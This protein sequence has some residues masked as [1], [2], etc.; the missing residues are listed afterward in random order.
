MRWRLPNASGASLQVIGAWAGIGAVGFLAGCLFPWVGQWF[1]AASALLLIPFVLG[2][3]RRSLA[4]GIVFLFYLGFGVDVPMALSAAGGNA[5]LTSFF[6]LMACAV[7]A[8][9]PV[10]LLR[11]RYPFLRGCVAALMYLLP[12]MGVLVPGNPFLAIGVILPATGAVGVLLFVAVAGTLASLSQR[13]WRTREYRPQQK[14][15]IIALAV[16]PV[17]SNAIYLVRGPVQAPANWFAVSMASGNMQSSRLSMYREGPAAVERTWREKPSVGVDS[18][19]VLFFPEGVITGVEDGYKPAWL[20]AVAGR[21]LGVVVGWYR[22]L[23]SS[24][25]YESRIQV[26]GDAQSAYIGELS[27]MSQRASVAMPITMWNPLSATWHFPMQTLTPVSFINGIATRL[28]WCYEST[29]I[30]PHLL[31][32]VQG[33]QVMVSMENH[34]SY[35]GTSLE[36]AQDVT[37]TLVARWLGVHAL[38][39]INR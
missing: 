2:A 36:R 24:G 14:L 18:D 4:F 35:Q 20:Q 38:R 11:G 17:V 39:A 22:P 26:L 13:A 34:W 21:K 32:S 25:R 15:A 30:W 37:T 8:A 12:P 27:V 29:I 10:L 1:T 7:M 31:A 16:V 28:S 9:L 3:V 6:A 33:V 5:H 19:A 23:D